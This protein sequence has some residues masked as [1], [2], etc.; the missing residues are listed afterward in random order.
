MELRKRKV[1]QLAGYSLAEEGDVRCPSLAATC[2]VPAADAP[3]PTERSWL[4]VDIPDRVDLSRSAWAHSIIC[5]GARLSTGEMRLLQ[6]HSAALRDA[7]A[8]LLTAIDRWKGILRDMPELAMAAAPAPGPGARPHTALFPRPRRAD[9]LSNQLLCECQLAS[10]GATAALSSAC[11][12]PRGPAEWGPFDGPGCVACLFLRLKET[13]ESFETYIRWLR[14][15]KE[16]TGGTAARLAELALEQEKRRAG[17][18]PPA[19]KQADPSPAE[20][21]PPPR[22]RPARRG[23]TGSS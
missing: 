1:L 20:E 4:P 16:G 11:P 3:E 15:Q 8:A 2:L 10:G 9:P 19:P 17:S 14:H 18:P 22:P 12:F 5:P 7:R 6:G 13:A 23:R 21:L